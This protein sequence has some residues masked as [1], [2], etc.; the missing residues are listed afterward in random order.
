MRFAHFLALLALAPLAL[1]QQPGD[2]SR[3]TGAAERLNAPAQ[4]KP[5][6]GAAGDA[7]LS[8]D[9]LEDIG[10]LQVLSAAPR[11]KWFEAGASVQ[12]VYSDNVAL[13]EDRL[14]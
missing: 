7:E 13:L 5:E 6:S 12:S 3:L 1:A 8:V 9:D 10:P 11:H 4:P 14:H 2:A